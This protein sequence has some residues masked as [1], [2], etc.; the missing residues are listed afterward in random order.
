MGADDQ[1]EG[2][3]ICHLSESYLDESG[4]SHIT[5]TVH[6]PYHHR[7]STSLN[8][9]LLTCKVHGF[10]RLS[11]YPYTS[12]SSIQ[13]ETSRQRV[14]SYQ[15]SNVGVDEPR[16]NVKLWVVQSTRAHEWA[17]G[18]ESPYR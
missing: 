17:F 12:I 4:V 5:P 15:Q 14:S 11:P 2:L 3:H 18:Y 7:A 8:S 13:L 1:T 10:M 9:P 6:V 16:Q